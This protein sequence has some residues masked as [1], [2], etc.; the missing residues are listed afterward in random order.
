MDLESHVESA[1]NRRNLNCAFVA[2]QED[3]GDKQEVAASLAD[4]KD[5]NEMKQRAEAEGKR[6][7]SVPLLS[8]FGQSSVKTL[9]HFAAKCGRRCSVSRKKQQRSVTP[10]LHMVE[11]QRVQLTPRL[12]ES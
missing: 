9:Q 3:G 5:A 4:A 8:G 7:V 2:K 10:H 12:G 6:L 11:R 1:A